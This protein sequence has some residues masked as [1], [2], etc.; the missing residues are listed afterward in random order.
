VLFSGLV[1]PSAF[2]LGTGNITW[3]SDTSAVST[4][5]RVCSNPPPPRAP[6]PPPFPPMQPPPP[7]APPTPPRAPHT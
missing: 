6:P 4:G 2:T 3:L 7:R 5:W 1:G